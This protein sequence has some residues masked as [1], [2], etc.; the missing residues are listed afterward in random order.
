[1][2]WPGQPD[3]AHLRTSGAPK[4]RDIRAVGSH[5]LRSGDYYQALDRLEAGSTCADS[6]L[7]H[8]LSACV[9]SATSPRNP[10][11]LST[12]L[13]LRTTHRLAPSAE[14]LGQIRLVA[15]VA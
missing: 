10:H 5:P 11:G 1:M 6:T 13:V 3:I 4:V 8:S 9:F 12:G 14:A 2:G 7:T 15:P